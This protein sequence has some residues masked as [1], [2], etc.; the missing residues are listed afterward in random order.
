MSGL[1]LC[2]DISARL[3]TECESFCIFSLKRFDTFDVRDCNDGSG[4]SSAES[5][6]RFLTDLVADLV[7]ALV[8]FACKLLRSSLALSVSVGLIDFLLVKLYS[9]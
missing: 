9:F 5:R 3:F 4:F 8:S 7:N 6:V 2:A 1:D